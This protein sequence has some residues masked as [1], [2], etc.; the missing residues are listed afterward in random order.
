M[1]VSVNSFDNITDLFHSLPAVPRT[2]SVD[3][4]DLRSVYRHH[5]LQN[6]THQCS[7]SSP[8]TDSI[9]PTHLVNMSIPD[10][11]TP[12]ISN[13][14]GPPSHN[15]DS[16]TNPFASVSLINTLARYK[17]NQQ[18]GPHLSS[19]TNDILKQLLI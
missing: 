2:I 5:P 9:I 10:L 15:N 19:D 18:T 8:D 11:I 3:H 13:R 7:P 4:M 17:S 12:Q 14:P 6:S 16:S 1:G